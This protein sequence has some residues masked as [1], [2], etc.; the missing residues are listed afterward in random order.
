MMRRF[1]KFGWWWLAFMHVGIIWAFSS[2][3]GS[4][5]G[6][7][8]PFDKAAH[9]FSFALLGFLFAKALNSPRLGFVLAAL[10]GIA[11]ELHQSTVPLRDANFWDWVADALGAY[12]G[13]GAISVRQSRT[14]QINPPKP[15]AESQNA[16]TVTAQAIEDNPVQK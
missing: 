4:E 6:L 9:F 10:Y 11:D 13:S 1:F 8:P 7:P 2:R 15:K 14:T 16:P 5:V 12:F 3:T